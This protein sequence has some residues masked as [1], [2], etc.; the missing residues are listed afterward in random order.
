MAQDFKRYAEKN[1]GATAVDIPNAASFTTNDTI[2]GINLSNRAAIAIKASVYI[3][4]AGASDILANRNYLV[5]DAPI[6]SGGALQLLDGGAKV[7][8]Q[9]QD[10][11]YIVSDT[12]SSLDAWIS[13]VADISQ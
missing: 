6:P 10:T 12:A 4:L 5:K 3:I 11:L 9:N 8:V 2:V 7:V 13:V 1:I